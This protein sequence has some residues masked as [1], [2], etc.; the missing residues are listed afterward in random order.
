MMRRFL[1]GAVC[2]L[3][4]VPAAALAE[5]GALRIG[6]REDPDQLDPTL[7]SAFV[8]RI[9]YAS[10]CDKLF[11][12]DAKLN[13]VPQLSTGFEYTDPTHLILRLREGVTF[14]D[15]EKM[16]ADAVK[17]S[18]MRHLTAKGSMRAGEINVI[19]AVEV[20]DPKKVQLILKS[21]A[22]QIL[23]QLADRA[24][25]IMSPKALTEGTDFGQHPV[26]VGPFAFAERVAQDRIVLKRDPNYWDAKNYHFDQVT[27]LPM[28]NS[29]IR[30]ANLQA[31]S[32]DLVEFIAPTDMA[33]VERDP[34][35]KLAVGDALGYTSINFNTGNGPAAN[36]VT[37]Q[38]ALV[39]RAFELSIDR[40]AL[41]QVVY[42]GLFVPTAQANPPSSPMFVNYVEPPERDIA[43]AK[44]LLKRAGVSL[45]VP[46]TLTVTNSPD[47]QQAAEVIQSMTKEAGFDVKL[48]TME[49]A[50]SLQAAYSGDFQAYMIE[51]GPAVP[52]RRQHLAVAAH[53]RYL[54]LR[55]LLQPR[56][57][58]PA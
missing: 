35:L 4:L 34:K 45:P 13:I 41:I 40:T 9:V 20:V 7:G 29:S 26:C 39:R 50:S 6:V 1:L 25:I 33:T 19:Q 56:C 18:L 11:D 54:Q 3:A 21:P 8:S 36:T 49:F 58:P 12:I 38:N 32:L 22:S 5:G 27:Y 44:E 46:I 10:M 43:K 2:A 51:A 47:I 37:G 52:M 55:P 42:N 31:G 57:G 28:P 53:R 48:K 30:L 16:D 23:A 17:T 15:G 24:G 14:Q